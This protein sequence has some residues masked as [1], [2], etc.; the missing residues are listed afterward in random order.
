MSQLLHIDFS[1]R[2]EESVSRQLTA[3]YAN[4]WKAAHPDGTVVYRDYGTEPVPH[5]SPAGAEVK[6]VPPADHT[7][8]Q[9]AAYAIGT[10]LN[11]DVAAADT[12]VLGVPLYNYGPPSAIKAWIDN[13]VIGGVSHNP[14]TQES[15]LG[16]TELIVL[17]VKGGAYG[18]GTPRAGWDHF[19]PW[20]SHV[21]ST[22]GLT[23]RYIRSEMTL[24]HTVPALFEFQDI[25]NASRTA[26]EAEIDA[27]WTPEPVA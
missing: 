24:A 18:E 17:A 12:V 26:A 3:R 20:F 7:P 22:I 19:E 15:L 23:P 1:L 9:A 5:L 14:E 10:G 21:T 11:A 25:A 2:H 8:A 6:F 16:D 4:R 13:L 27:L